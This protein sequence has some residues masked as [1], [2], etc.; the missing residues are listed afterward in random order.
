MLSFSKKFANKEINISKQLSSREIVH[1]LRVLEQ[2]LRDNESI[3]NQTLE[4]D[5]IEACIYNNK[6]LKSRYRYFHNMARSRGI[7]LE[8][9]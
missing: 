8:N 3:F 4:N 6:A 7:R 1:E 9:L 5:L 2:Q